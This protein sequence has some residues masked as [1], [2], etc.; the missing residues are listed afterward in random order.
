MT[1]GSGAAAAH[2]FDDVAVYA[3]MIAAVWSIKV[4]SMSQRMALG[5][6]SDGVYVGISMTLA[7]FGGESRTVRLPSS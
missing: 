7:S 4:P 1:S 6:G 2:G 5:R 3:R